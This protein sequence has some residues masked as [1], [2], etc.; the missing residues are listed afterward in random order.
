MKTQIFFLPDLGE[1]LPDAEVVQWAVQVGD[2]VTLDGPLVSME[3]AKAVV[4]V[5]S[6]VS[7]TLI[8]IFGA[9]GDVIETGKPLAEFELSDGQQRAQAHATGHTHG[10]GTA[11]EVWPEAVP[12]AV[13]EAESAPALTNSQDAGSVVGAVNVSN[14]LVSD[15]VVQIAGIK[16]VP[17]VRALARKLQVDLARVRATGQDG[18]VTFADV[19]AAAE[20]PPQKNATPDQGLDNSQPGPGQVGPGQVGPGQVSDQTPD[21][22]P[23]FDQVQAL[24]GV[25]R[26]MARAMQQAHAAVV[27]TTLTEDADLHAW[28]PGQDLTCRLIRALVAASRV[29]PGLNAWFDGDAL[30]RILHS[31][32]DIGLAVDTSEGLFVPALRGAQ[33]LSQA[34]LKAQVGQLRDAVLARSLPA[35]AL[36]GYTIML[37]NFGMYAGRYATPVI[38]PPC[39]AIVAAGRARAQLVPVLGGIATHRILPLSLSFDHRACTG[40]EAARFLRALLLDLESMH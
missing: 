4:D 6:P 31:R 8:K 23:V 32:V 19:K 18:I 35:A 39:V 26:N 33:N 28:L 37:S 3:T 14:Q 40:G 9:K 7:G 2:S 24:R 16:A 17:A 25:R 5:P 12:E 15:A 27:P 21:Q 38:A 13:P 20:H 11:P 22:A 34:Q 30:S 10:G 36:S 29:E 1:G